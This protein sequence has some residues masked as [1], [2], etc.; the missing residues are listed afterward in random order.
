M[1]KINL[2]KKINWMCYIISVI[3]YFLFHKL[4]MINHDYAIL[5]LRIFFLLSIIFCIIPIFFKNLSTK[6]KVSQMIFVIFLLVGFLI[7]LFL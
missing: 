4:K 3:E 1:D 5:S 2:T 7:S 6:K